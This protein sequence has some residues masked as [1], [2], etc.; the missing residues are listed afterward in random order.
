MFFLLASGHYTP[1]IFYCQEVVYPTPIQHSFGGIQRNE[2]SILLS[3][4]MTKMYVGMGQVN[5]LFFFILHDL[6]ITNS[7]YKSTLHGHS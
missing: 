3:V 1:S 5:L 2:A 7:L 6:G 4:Q